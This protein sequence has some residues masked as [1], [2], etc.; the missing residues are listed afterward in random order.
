MRVGSNTIDNNHYIMTYNG[1][2]CRT[3][4]AE[5]ARANQHGIRNQSYVL[6]SF[7]VQARTTYHILHMGK[8]PYKP[9]LEHK[10]KKEG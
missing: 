3:T 2:S 1:S 10:K 7:R 4:N 6:F 8:L 9:Y 5:N